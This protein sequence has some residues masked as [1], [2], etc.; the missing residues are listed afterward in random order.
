M[1]SQDAGVRQ[2]VANGYDVVR[3]ACRFLRTQMMSQKA[4]PRRRGVPVARV[5]GAGQTPQENRID[6]MSDEQF[7]AFSRQARAAAMMGKKVKM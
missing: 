6:A 3:A 2:D 4:A 1:L 5:M 7:D